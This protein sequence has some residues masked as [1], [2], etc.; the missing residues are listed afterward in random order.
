MSAV[1]SGEAQVSLNGKVSGEPRRYATRFA[2]PATATDNP[3]IE[4]L[5]AYSTIERAT[6]EIND[7]G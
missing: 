7:F 6:T 1:S 4:R 5:W 2:F 3:E